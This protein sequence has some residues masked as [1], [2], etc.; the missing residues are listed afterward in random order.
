[1]FQQWDLSVGINIFKLEHYDN[2]SNSN[3]K[4]KIYFLVLIWILRQNKKKHKKH[5]YILVLNI[6][7]GGGW[8]MLDRL[9]MV[10]HTVRVH[11]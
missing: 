4:I 11:W 8:R 6:N 3:S 2:P 1:M 10:K 7:I 5:Y 9:G